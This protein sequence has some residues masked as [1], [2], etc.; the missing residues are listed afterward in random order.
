MKVSHI[1][2]TKKYYTTQVGITLYCTL[3][4]YNLLSLCIGV[5]SDI[6]NLIFRG[7]SRREITSNG[8]KFVSNISQDASDKEKRKEILASS[9]NFLRL[10][11]KYGYLHMKPAYIA[12]IL[13]GTI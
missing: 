1:N 7:E 2:R 4:L 11:A 12:N 8:V 13:I 10:L 9:M 5:F 6:V 3:L